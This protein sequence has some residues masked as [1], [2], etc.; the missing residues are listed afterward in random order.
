MN[1]KLSSSWAGLIFM[2]LSLVF[3]IFDLSK[4]LTGFL[5]FFSY[6]FLKNELRLTK[7]S[8]KK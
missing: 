4:W 8:F 1:N 6:F 5:I 3:L 2:L 7:E